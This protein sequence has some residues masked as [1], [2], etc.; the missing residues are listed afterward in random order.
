MTDAPLKLEDLASIIR[1]KNAGPFRIT[2][3][4]LFRDNSAYR[5]MR[6]SGVLSRKTIAQAYRISE[7]DIISIYEVDMANAFKITI[8]RSVTQGDVGDSDVYG[9]QQHVP[10]MGIVVS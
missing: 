9:A 6:E 3:D 4:I 1:S 5:R 8:A 2:F 10:L 7:S